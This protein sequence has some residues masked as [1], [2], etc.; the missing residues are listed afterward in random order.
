MK[1]ILII[2]DELDMAESMATLLESEGYEAKTASSAKIGLEILQQTIPD[3]VI[4]DVMMPVTKGTELA[5][6]IR[7]DQKLAK[8]P[9]LLTSASRE[10]QKS[11]SDDWN[12]FLRKPFDIDEL[13]SDVRKLI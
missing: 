13:L 1:N 7:D 11:N 5:R 2:D 6:I 12:H 9:I 8:I 3:L 10:P 4:L